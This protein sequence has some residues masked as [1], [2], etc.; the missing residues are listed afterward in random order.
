MAG[1]ACTLPLAWSWS[2][3]ALFLLPYTLWATLVLV[4]AAA[5]FS[6]GYWEMTIARSAPTAAQPARHALV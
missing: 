3:L 6:L 1:R 2:F 5:R 4:A